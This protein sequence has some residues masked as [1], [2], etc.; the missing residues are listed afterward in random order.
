[1]YARWHF[2]SLPIPSLS[3]ALLD[4][5]PLQLR[6]QEKR[7]HERG[8]IAMS[9]APPSSSLESQHSISADKRPLLEPVAPKAD[10]TADH[11]A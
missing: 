3:T 2:T 9:Q 1:M 11:N 10:Q 4:S 8:R 5:S 6:L 7:T